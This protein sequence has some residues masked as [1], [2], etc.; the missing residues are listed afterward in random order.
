M[1]KL[2]RCITSDG[3]VTVIAVDAT[4]I[5]NRAEQIHQTSAVVTAG[6]GRLL[7][8][9]SMMGAMLKGEKASITLRLQ[10]DG[11][12]SPIVA[13]A[14]PQGNVKGYAGKK[15]LELP[16]NQYGK[17]D[18]SGAFGKTG[19]L[20]VMKD[21]GAG[22]PYIG[23]SPIVSGEIAED[24]AHYYAVSEQIPTVCALGVLVNPD[25]SVRAAGGFIA[26]LLPAADHREIDR[27]EE[28]IKK[29][30]PITTMLNQGM[31]IESICQ[32]VLD[33][34]EMEILE[35]SKVEYR[36]DCSLEKVKKA[37]ITLGKE[38][39]QTLPN[40]EGMTEVTCDFCDQTYHFT[41][42][43]LDMLIL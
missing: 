16:L 33:G 43:Q 32:K 17:L 27:L 18:V 19:L 5:V 14:D 39:L 31:D 13:V 1:G 11:A 34:F 10:G 6:L 25:L 8:A 41:R 40:E 3:L 23:Q 12:A 42:E 24:I 21:F 29:L 38:E 15:V 9:A 2:I 37:L 35:E 4:D 26:Q 28:N 7:T 22:E 36:C 20:Y 30:D